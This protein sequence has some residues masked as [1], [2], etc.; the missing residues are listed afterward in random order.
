MKRKY[1]ALVLGLT[2][3]ISSTV[4]YAEQ[5]EAV[6]EEIILEE[7]TDS[8]EELTDTEEYIMEDS[9]AAK[10]VYGKITA[11]DETSI[12]VEIGTVQDDMEMA[13]EE[14]PVLE[15]AEMINEELTD[16]ASDGEETDEEKTIGHKRLKHLL[17]P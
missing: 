16:A 7:S 17:F 13:E 12:T 4:V 5:T 15:E 8:S 10:E 11:I 1:A 3:A 9:E 6:S 14:A 2:L